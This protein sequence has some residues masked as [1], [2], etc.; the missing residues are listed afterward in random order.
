MARRKSSKQTKGS[1]KEPTT[2]LRDLEVKQGED[3]RGG[4]DWVSLPS[5]KV[6][7]ASRKVFLYPENWIQP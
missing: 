6:W 1:S 2:K 7:E 3:V 4:G 5:P